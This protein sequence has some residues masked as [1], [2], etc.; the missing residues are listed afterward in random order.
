[1]TDTRDTPPG[2]TSRRRFLFST[3]AVL[4]AASTLGACNKHSAGASTQT[5]PGDAGTAAH[6]PRFFNPEEWSTIQAAVDRLIPK[7]AEGPG[8]LELDVP[9]FIDRQMEG[10]FG[11]AATWYM[12]GPFHPDAP[13]L[14]GYQSP[15]TPR[16]LYRTGIAALDTY[17]RAHFSSKRFVDL[18]STDQDKVLHGLDAGTIKLEH[19]S[20]RNFIALLWQ[21]TKEGYFADPIHGGNKNAASWT[22][23]GFPGARADYLDWVAQPGKVYPLGTV[24]IERT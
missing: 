9:V 14:S 18:N 10:A 8:A 4:P 6:L 2:P 11:H 23:I 1:M 12:Q 24:T 13:P 15:M 21:N 3:I 16:D 5:S 20:A 7:D 17:C 19:A 22:M